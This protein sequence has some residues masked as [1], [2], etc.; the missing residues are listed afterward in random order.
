LDDAVIQQSL[1][2][3]RVPWNLAIVGV[4][5]GWSDANEWYWDIYVWKRRPWNPFSKLMGWVA[6]S[7]S[8]TAN[9]DD[10]VGDEHDDSHAYLFSRAGEPVAMKLWVAS[11]A[12][13]VGACSGVVLLVGLLA[14]FSGIGFRWLWMISA[15]LCFL[16]AV[17]AHPSTVLLFV[18]SALSGVVLVLLGCG[19]RRVLERARVVIPPVSATGS[20]PSQIG[21]GGTSAGSPGV[22]SDDSTAIRGRNSSTLDYAPAPLILTS[23]QQSPRGSLVEEPL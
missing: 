10:A 3:I 6:G 17:F 18:Q 22:G 13:I 2:E 11:R 8:Q 15:V 1:W 23:E 16:V 5:D 19:I 20:V 4:P 9:L 14:M 21:L 7:T 12:W